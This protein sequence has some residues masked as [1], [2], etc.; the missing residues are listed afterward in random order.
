MKPMLYAVF[1]LVLGVVVSQGSHAQFS[2]GDE[3][4]LNGYEGVATANPVAR[5][6][7]RLAN[8]ETAL[9]YRDNGRGYLD[10][11]LE[12][13]DIDTA[14][15]MLVFS[16][17]S[18][19]H[20]LISPERPRAVFFNDNTFIGFV[21]RSSIVEVTTIDNEKGIVFYT[22]DNALQT[23]KYFERSNQT[24]LV[25]HDT[26]GTMGGGIP[27]LMALSSVYSDR[28]VPLKNYSGIGNVVDQ[29][30]IADRWGG[31][32][33][34][35]SHGLQPHLGNILLED[36]ADLDRLDDFR[37]WNL[38]T[39][40]G[41]EFMD[42]SPYPSD[43]SDIVALMVL[44][45][46]VTVQNQITYIKFKAPAV[47]YRRGM[48][49]AAT[50]E[51]WAE[52]PAPAQQTLERMLD[53]LVSLMVMLDA[54]DLQSPIS[55]TPAYAEGFMA[56]GPHDDQGRT[57][58]E[59]DLRKRLFRYPLSFLIHTEDFATLPVYA[60]D[61]IYARLAAYLGGEDLYE[62]RSQYTLAERQEAL[63]IL[64]ATHAGF[65]SYLE[66]AETM[67]PVQASTVTTSW[68]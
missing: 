3:Y 13:L 5:L 40:A 46:Q 67:A 8:G 32:Y 53:K 25:C 14:S 35:G 42:P 10:S 68:R 27:M 7:A 28:N 23:T 26:Q 34:T 22:F 9:E 37:I 51:S 45:H 33:V 43:T 56:R 24:C 65:R 1:L 36:P 41:S 21:Q 55:G 39:L 59:L 50:A 30:P 16:P 48:T 54:A 66:R 58:R 52:L 20:K 31:W 18:L 60:M 57:L 47:F 62:G 12:A 29:T 2:A 63:D 6:Q 17:T 61:F 44:E 64:T 49:E 38:E 11:L 4:A 19:Q 15:Q